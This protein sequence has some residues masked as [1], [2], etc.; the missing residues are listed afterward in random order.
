MSENVKS[1]DRRRSAREALLQVRDTQVRVKRRSKVS[2]PVL[3]LLVFGAQLTF[4]MWMN[5]RGFVFIDAYSRATN[6]LMVLYST[7]PHLAA[8]GFVWMPLPSLIELLWVAFFPLWPQIVSSGFASTLTTA[9]AGGATAA[10]L[11][12]TARRLDLSDRLGWAFALVVAANPMLFLYASNGLSEGVVAPFLTGAVCFLVLFWHSG[13]RRYVTAA[14]LALALGFASLYEAV[15]YGAALF[16]A[17]AMGL[18]WGSEENAPSAPQ[19]RRRA[20]EGL[21][22]LLLV[23]SFYVAALW[24]GANA[25]IMG[26]PLY[27]ATSEYSNVGL[28]VSIG[29]G[30]LARSATADAFETLGYVFA[31]LSVFLIPVGFLLLIRA[32][33]G[34]LWRT[35]T[36]SL[37]LLLLSVP[38]GLIAPLLYLGASYG[39]LRFFIYPLFVAAGWGLYEVVLS[40]HPRRASAF[41][42]VGWIVAAPLTLWAMHN[43]DLGQEEH[44]LVKSLLTG[45]SA[46]QLSMVNSEGQKVAFEDWIDETTPVANYLDEKV[47]S[48]E[49]SVALD[50]FGG[51]SIAAQVQPEYLKRFLLLTPDQS[52]KPAVRDPR[53]HDLSYIIVPNPEKAPQSE[54]VRVYPDLWAGK[55]EGFEFVTGFE[56]TPH[57]WR[58]Y[59]VVPPGTG[60]LKRNI[61][62][63]DNEY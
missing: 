9:L 14:G 52:F 35:N 27:F 12:Y 13:K 23:P 4:G 44:W 62:R 29:A 11:L 8:I 43:P 16:A 47:L 40:R 5:S 25:I 53:N 58:V 28:T 20:V 38:L 39:W 45:K 24:V 17:L 54:V 21:G 2:L 22:I 56:E 26:D 15:P 31:R 34:R 63:L 10:L 37:V 42:L 41:L 46:D 51:S 30:G 32:L 18:M 3:F 50:A 55:Q 57:Q 59:K 33:D 6:A 1:L 36:L 48:K 61:N 19:G 60:E 49:N 7:D